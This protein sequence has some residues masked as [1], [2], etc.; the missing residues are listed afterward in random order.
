MLETHEY[1]GYWWLPADADGA[2]GFPSDQSNMRSGTLTIKRG[3]AHL[4]ILSSFGHAELGQSEDS[5]K[6]SLFPAPQPRILGFTA[7]GERI[8]LEDCGVSDAPMH[9]PGIPMTT[10]R[11]G[12]VYVGT[13]FQN[14]QEITFNEV[15]LQ[16][17]ELATWTGARA[18]RNLHRLKSGAVTTTF[19]RPAPIR[20]PLNNGEAA[21]IEFQV[22]F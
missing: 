11:A 7:K 1:D 15:A 22:A 20:I 14:D 3:V 17:S 21:I 13:W 16:T 6:L 5:V 10:Y 19:K 2:E 12:V 8:T 18:Y 9:F 4:K